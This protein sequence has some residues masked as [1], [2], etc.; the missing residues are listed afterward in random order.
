M[1]K[2]HIAL[3]RNGHYKKIKRTLAGP[4]LQPETELGLLPEGL[5]ELQVDRFSTAAHDTQGVF[6]RA[7]VLVQ[8]DSMPT[9]SGQ[10]AVFQIPSVNTPAGRDSKLSAAQATPS[11]NTDNK[12]RYHVLPTLP[13]EVR[14]LKKNRHSLFFP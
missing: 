4:A 5:P 13:D 11:A 10:R 8:D 12:V 9:L 2:P 3:R 14:Q 1:G 7:G 6:P